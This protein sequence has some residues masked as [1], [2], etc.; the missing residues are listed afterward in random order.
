MF[1]IHAFSYCID[2]M[3]WRGP[4]TMPTAGLRDISRPDLLQYTRVLLHLSFV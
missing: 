2:Y 1:V 3:T 4:V